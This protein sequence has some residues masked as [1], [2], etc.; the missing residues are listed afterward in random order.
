MD[1]AAERLEFA[2]PQQP[3]LVRGVVLA[4]IAHLLLLVGLTSG[5]QWKREAQEVSA[6]AE[7]WSATPQEAAPRE[8]LAPPPPPLP[9]VKAPPQP[10]PPAP[11]QRD[12]DIA[13]EREKEKQRIAEDKRRLAEE[14]RERE[15][16]REREEKRREAAERQ[17]ELL[18]ERQKLLAE[19]RKLEAEIQ[20]RKELE[21]AKKQQEQEKK[22]AQLREEN[23][24]RMQ[25]MA[26]GTGSPSSSGTAAQ[27]SG[28]SASW[29]GRVR[30]RVRPNIVFGD[31]V[32]GNPEAVIEV[33]LAPDGTIV[34]KRVKKSSGLKSWDDAVLRALDKTETLPRDVDGR[35]PT[36]VELAFRPKD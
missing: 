16:A 18:A 23:L 36:V 22:V 3:G 20:K 26:G 35:V 28:P 13:L 24:K 33:R 7:L 32:S 11:V 14:K 27:S 15:I 6:S 17:K 4:L 21:Q 31:D 30:A 25:G 8:V 1:A 12:A 19:K 5:L 29:A 10:E 9:V 34:G 2:P